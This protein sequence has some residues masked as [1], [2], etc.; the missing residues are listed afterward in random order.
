MFP[1]QFLSL[2][3]RK[4]FQVFRIIINISQDFSKS[5]SHLQGSIDIKRLKKDVD[6]MGENISKKAKDF[7][8]TMEQFEKVPFLK[9]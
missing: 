9:V 1:P 3:K 5:I 4:T 6:E 2:A 8:T 7:L